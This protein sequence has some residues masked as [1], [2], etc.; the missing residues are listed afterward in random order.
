M[1]L[2][3]ISKKHVNQLLETKY[4]QIDKYREHDNLI[5]EATTNAKLKL[6]F[7]QLDFITKEINQ[8]IDE[9]LTNNELNSIKCSFTK[10]PGKTY[11]VYCHQ[12][13]NSK[14]MQN[15]F[16][17]WYFSM[18]SPLEWNNK[19]YIASFQY[20]ID[21]SYTKINILNE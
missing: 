15:N 5:L 7:K 17:D 10:I 9:A 12:N 4:N 8:V 16:N 11:H 14:K 6:L 13:S 21:G 19:T 20:N 3:N 18:I 2:S 1:A